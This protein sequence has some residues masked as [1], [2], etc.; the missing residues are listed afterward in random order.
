VLQNLNKEIKKIEGGSLKG[1]ISAGIIVIRDMEK[2][3]PKIPID[4]SNLRASRF[5]VTSKG[6]TKQGS[7]PEFIGEDAAKLSTEHGEVLSENLV[8]AK[9]TRQ[10]TVVLGFSANYAMFVH[11]MVGANFGREGSG[12]KFLEAS[13][14]RNKDKILK[15]IQGGAK[16]R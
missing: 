15:A 16:I 9:A 6:G 4:T 12:A 14:K 5:L 8:L 2:T 3:P 1:L 13:L 10:P 11:E 7:S